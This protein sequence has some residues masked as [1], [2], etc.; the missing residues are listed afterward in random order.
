MSRLHSMQ[1]RLYHGRPGYV[2][3]IS[4]LVIGA[5]AAE[6]AFSLILLGLAGGQSSLSLSQSAQAYE[7]AQTCIERAI[8]DLQA[9]ISYDGGTAVPFDDGSCT[10]LHTGGSGN[11]DRALCVEGRNGKSVRRFEIALAR[12]HPSVAISSW[13]EVG[14]FSLCP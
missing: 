9:D 11:A 1:Y 7:H 12:I 3:L 14:A 8:R 2:F 6:M 5:I 13:R 10:V 4:V